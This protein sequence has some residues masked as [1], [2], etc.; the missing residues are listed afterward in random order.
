MS[1]FSWGHENRKDCSLSGGSG[2]TLVSTLTLLILLHAGNELSDAEVLDH[3][4]EDS[5]VTGIDVGNLD[6]GF[7]G[8]EIHL[9]LSF[10]L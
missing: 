7:L 9:S 8:D 6:L 5:I 1:L 10:L 2:S 3:L 4:L